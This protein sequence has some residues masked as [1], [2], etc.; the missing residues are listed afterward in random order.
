VSG[1][2]ATLGAFVAA[3][4]VVIGGRHRIAVETYNPSP[5]P[6]PEQAG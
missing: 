3:A 5:K 6:P 4:A 1:A 2:R